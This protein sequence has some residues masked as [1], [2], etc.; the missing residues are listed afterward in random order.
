MHLK[1]TNRALM[2]L[3]AAI[4]GLL[5]HSAAQAQ[6]ADLIFQNGKVVTVDNNFSVAEAVAVSGNKIIGVGTNDEIK[7]LAGPNTQVLD[8]KGRTVVPGLVDTH[9]HSYSYAEGAYGG[10]LGEVKLHR[11]P[12]D[13]RGV[14]TKEDVL[15]QLKGLMAKYNFKPGQWVYFVNQ[16][17]FM[18]RE[19]GSVEQA[20]ILYDELNQWE[21]DKVTPNNPIIMS[22][23]IPDFNGFLVNKKAMDYLMGKYGDF[24]KKNGRF[25]IDARGLPDGHLEPPASRLVLPFTYDRPP[26]TLAELYTRQIQEENSMGMTTVISR[27]PSDSLAAFKMLE[28]K[29]ELNQ[30]EGY[31]IIEAFGYGKQDVKSPGS[32]KQYATQIG[33]G[34]DKVWVTG[35]G[36]TAVD[37]TTS[38]ACTNQKR[39]GTYS[40]IDSWFPVGQ[41]H[42]DSEYKGS[43]KRAANISENYYREWVMASGRDGVRLANVHVAGD[44]AVGL[45]LNSIEQ[46]HKQYGSTSTKTWAFDHCDMVDPAD[47]KRLGALGV[48]MSCYV[49]HSV[50]R[51]PQM[52]EA[53]GDKVANTFPSPLKSMLDAGVK[54]VLESDSNTYVWTDIAAAINRKDH[55]G[56]VWAAQERVDRPT[57]LRMY[58]Q[59]AADYAL[60]GDQLGSI[61]KGK[62]A[63]LVVLDKDYLTMA[64][65]E[66]GK[67]AP[68]L[69]VFDG[70]MVYVH[71]QFA[72]EYS[73]QPK[74]ATIATFQDLIARRKRVSNYSGGG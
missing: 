67:I 6:N 36:P 52:A 11:Y 71:P 41:C 20:K 9:R 73:L 42:M 28:S 47:F 44:R 1:I 5:V 66:I 30:R 15:N 70:R 51:S 74:G 22:L 17:Q 46:I 37:G 3:L 64:A 53:Y 38:R 4:T 55:T 26:E 21:L 29:G 72:Q 50:E 34:T 25:W 24:I 61:Q 19:G 13:W 58:T 49:Q 68:Q 12:V 23:G 60:R 35:T 18:G 45:L 59:W 31:G 16:L 56:K 32:L 62:M 54:V 8:L 57:A 40:N 2:L 69:T 43:P 10:L 27:M 14:R 39:S 65:D 48:T 63:D 33:S 7:K